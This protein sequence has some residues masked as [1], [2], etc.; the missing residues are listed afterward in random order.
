MVVDLDDAT[1]FAASE[2]DVARW[3]ALFGYSSGVAAGRIE[4]GRR[5]AADPERS[6]DRDE[7]G[8]GDEEGEREREARWQAVRGVMEGRGYDR[9]AFEHLV[10]LERRGER[11]GREEGAEVD[12]GRGMVRG[13]GIWGMVKGYWRW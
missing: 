13:R 9:E 2:A 12:R 4:E 11:V 10:E 1:R 3:V 7:D 6:W 8:D 5:N